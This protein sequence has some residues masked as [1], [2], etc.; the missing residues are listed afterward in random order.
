MSDTIDITGEVCPMTWVR[1]KLKLEGLR[2]GTLL[3][4]RLKGAEPLRN[5][6]RNAAEDGHL[7]R[8]LEHLT[9]GTARL[10]IE[11]RHG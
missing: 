11:V 4:V 3:E 9:D 5:L 10:L 1:V 6:P 8:E 2:S 7:V